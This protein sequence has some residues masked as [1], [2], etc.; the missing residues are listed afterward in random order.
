MV[1]YEI[2][3][4]CTACVHIVYLLNDAVLNVDIC[5][6]GE[7]I[8]DHLPSLDENTHRAHVGSHSPIRGTKKTFHL[9]LHY[10]HEDH[11]VNT[12]TTELEFCAGSFLLGKKNW[13]ITKKMLLNDSFGVSERQPNWKPL[14][15][16][17]LPQSCPMILCKNEELHFA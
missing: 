17:L 2:V 3:C 8:I 13:E 14:I 7:V 1:F 9:I 15:C 10:K 16:T 11:N 12:V 5:F 4:I 6:L